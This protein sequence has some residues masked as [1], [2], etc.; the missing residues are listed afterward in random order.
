MR[1]TFDSVTKVWTAPDKPY[2]FGTKTIGEV[3]FETL[4]KNADAALEVN[5]DTGK[6]L[7]RREVKKLSVNIAVQFKELG[8]KPDEIVVLLLENQDYAGAIFLAATYITAPFCAL[9]LG[10]E[11]Q[12]L[13]NLLYTLQPRI[14]VCEAYELEKVKSIVAEL[15]LRHCNVFVESGDTDDLSCDNVKQLFADKGDVSTFKP[16]PIDADVFED[17]IAAIVPSSATTGT[18]KLISLSHPQLLHN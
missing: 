3:V 9:E 13:R 8:V 17:K 14:I 12:T 10:M 15:N 11:R 16:T 7:T 18:Y 6:V 2:I 4:D 1:T 5:H